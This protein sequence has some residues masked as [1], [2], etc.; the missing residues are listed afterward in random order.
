MFIIYIIDI[1]AELIIIAEMNKREDNNISIANVLNQKQ[2][3]SQIIE[4]LQISGSL[5]V[6]Y[7]AE[8]LGTSEVTIRKDLTL[9]ENKKR[10]YRSHGKAILIESHT[11]NK[12]INL[13]EK[14]NHAEK[15]AIGKEAAK[16]IVQGDSIIIGSGTTALF[17]AKEINPPAS[18][19]ILTSSIPVAT[20]VSQKEIDEVVVLGGIMRKSS[21]STVG[22]FAEHIINQFACNK[23]F[24]GV[25]GVDLEFGITTTNTLEANLNRE[26]LKSSGKV[27]VLA[28]S[29]KFN[30]RG[31]SKICNI[32]EVDHIIT[33]SNITQAQIKEVENLGIALTIAQV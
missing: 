1:F 14:I 10:L 2:R 24:L 33:D 29:S 30:R 12:H 4:M 7:I 5:S 6:G 27:I 17:F 28:D 9:L 22:P 15:I 20:E 23:L 8:K 32:N 11:F 19:T 3:H 21:I 25:D 26:M 16:M 13:K 31:F 18:V